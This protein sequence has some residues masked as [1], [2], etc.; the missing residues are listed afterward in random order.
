M[1]PYCSSKKLKYYIYCTVGT[2][3]RD[4]SFLVGDCQTFGMNVVSLNVSKRENFI[5]QVVITT[6]GDPN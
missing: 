5:C 4:Y 3:S 6:V 2:R 1:T